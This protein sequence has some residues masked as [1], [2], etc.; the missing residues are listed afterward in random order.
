MSKETPKFYQKG[1]F[2]IW[3]VLVSGLLTLG[4]GLILIISMAL[5]I[6]E[7][8]FVLQQK[9]Y[10][11]NNNEWK[12]SKQWMTSIIACAIVFLIIGVCKYGGLIR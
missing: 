11:C 3:I 7:I 1:F 9:I 10:S 12:V 6:G 5:L 2:H 8:I 4:F